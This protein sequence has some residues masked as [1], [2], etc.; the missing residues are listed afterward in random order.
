MITDPRPWMVGRD[1]GFDKLFSKLPKQ[2]RERIEEHVTNPA[3]DPYQGDIRKLKGES[4]AWAKR[5][6]EYR[7]FYEVDQPRHTID[8]Y[9]V[10]RRNTQTYRRGKQKR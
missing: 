5:L 4:N 7:V 3:F 6:G 1:A 8:V 2:E 10:E 9:H